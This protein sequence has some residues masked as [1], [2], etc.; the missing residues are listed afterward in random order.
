MTVDTHIRQ[1]PHK[2]D[3]SHTRH[4]Q[5]KRVIA[6]EE[7]ATR[8]VDAKLFAVVPTRNELFFGLGRP[9]VSRQEPFQHSALYYR[10]GPSV[11]LFDC[12]LAAHVSHGLHVIDRLG[13]LGVFA[14]HEFLDVG[15]VFLI[16]RSIGPSL[17]LVI[18]QPTET[19]CLR[20]WNWLAA[21]IA[22]WVEKACATATML[23]EF[24]SLFISEI[25]VVVA[26]GPCEVGIHLKDSLDCWNSNAPRTVVKLTK[27]SP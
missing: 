17:E 8:L 9:L 18:F 6:C 16:A 10:V 27:W 23:Y 12:G 4:F 24:I 5:A 21:G 13:P 19:H 7:L 15:L 14:V 26:F 1:L 3:M 2:V 11:H 20:Q 25:S 22:R